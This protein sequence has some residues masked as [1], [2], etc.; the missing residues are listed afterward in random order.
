MNDN[1]KKRKLNWIQKRTS[2][3]S[4]T[5]M[6]SVQILYVVNVYNFLLSLSGMERITSRPADVA[7]S[8]LTFV[9]KLETIPDY[10]FVL[11]IYRVLV[12]QPH[13]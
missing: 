10:V 2:S 3:V 4:Y 6:P 13:A 11:I 12:P 1:D 5:K 8:N 9:L 7:R